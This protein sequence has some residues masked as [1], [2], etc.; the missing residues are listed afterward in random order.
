[1]VGIKYKFPKVSLDL[2]SSVEIK[3][4]LLGISKMYEKH[5]SYTSY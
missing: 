2:A 5:F 4:K 1:M 3:K